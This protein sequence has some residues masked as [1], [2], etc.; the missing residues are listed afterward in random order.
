MTQEDTG[1]SQRT[2][3]G[4]MVGSSQVMKKGF[5]ARP[6][7]SNSDMH[8]TRHVSLLPSGRSRSMWPSIPA[9]QQACCQNLPA[10]CVQ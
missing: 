9:V 7:A 2:L 10:L 1:A 6:G 4:R 3:S 5:G 8:A